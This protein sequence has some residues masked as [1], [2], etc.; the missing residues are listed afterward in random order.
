MVVL[1]DTQVLLVVGQ[2]EILAFA[3]GR[4]TKTYCLLK[5]FLG[6]CEAAV[7]EAKLFTIRNL[8]VREHSYRVAPITDLVNCL[9]VWA[10]TMTQ[11]ARVV[12]MQNWVH[13]ENVVAIRVIKVPFKRDIVEVR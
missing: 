13:C 4:S 1:H 10:A 11:S 6:L 5:F 3:E 9:A 8:L 2:I 7:V 12:A